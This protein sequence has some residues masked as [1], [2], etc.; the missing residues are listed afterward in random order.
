MATISTAKAA[1][2]MVSPAPRPEGRRRRR[3]SWLWTLVAAAAALVAAFPLYWMLV[4]ALTPIADLRSSDY[5]LFPTHP[6]FAVFTNALKA[7]P[8]GHWYL[9]STVIAVA[10][11]ALTV[12]INL[13]CGY[14]F[15]KMRFPGKNLLFIAI[16]STLMIPIQVLMVSQFRIIVALGWLNSLWAVIIPRA[17]EAFGIFLARQY[18]RTI[19]DEV[20]DAARIDGA[21]ELTIF[22]RVVL[23]LAKPLIATLVIF[24]FMWRWNEFLWPLIVLKDQVSYT[25]PIGLLF[26]RGQY[27]SDY[28][29]LMAMT[30]LSMVPMILVF[31]FFQR[32]FVEGMTRS[33]I[34]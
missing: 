30:L 26:L 23:P 7:H 19:P 34:K 10:G 33:G 29:G 14:T 17:A 16:I 20:I 2:G 13:L 18:F 22:F 4:T 1:T 9:N 11:V 25:V 8:F 6:Q 32:F 31:A 3:T 21:G 12:S 28:N 27:T 15:A 24:T 5:S